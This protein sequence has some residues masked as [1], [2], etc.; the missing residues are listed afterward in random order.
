MNRRDKSRL[1]STK[2]SNDSL[3]LYDVFVY[4]EKGKKVDFRTNVIAWTRRE[5]YTNVM[6]EMKKHKT[7]DATRKCNI[8]D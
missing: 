7:W 2:N 3:G 6:G 4:N 1:K 8:G 5:A